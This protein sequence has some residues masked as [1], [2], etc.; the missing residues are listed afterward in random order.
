MRDDMHLFGMDMAP[1][2]R[3][4][5]LV[6]VTYLVLGGLWPLTWGIA[7]HPREFGLVFMYAGLLVNFFVFG[8]YGRWGLIKPFNHCR[9]RE[10]LCRNDE[11]ELHRRDRMHRP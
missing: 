5:A 11:R 7:G 1:R 10:G 9:G 6:A 4:R 8:G 2:S 3:R